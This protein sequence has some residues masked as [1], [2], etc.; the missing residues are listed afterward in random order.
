MNEHVLVLTEEQ[1]GIV[2]TTL[3]YMMSI[4][5]GGKR[6]TIEE[7]HARVSSQIAEQQA[8]WKAEER[9]QALRSA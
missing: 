4:A 6:R 8:D 1:A 9:A 3:V 7:T 5:T 2:A